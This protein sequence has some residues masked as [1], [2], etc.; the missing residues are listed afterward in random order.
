VALVPD[1]DEA[2][3]VL[4]RQP[5]VSGE[6][7]LRRQGRHHEL[8]VDGT[9]LMDTR[10]GRSE[11]LLARCA[12]DAAA[13]PRRVLVGGLGLG[14][15]LA[16]VLADPRVERVTVA[17]LEPVLVGWHR[18]FLRGLTGAA[19]V[20]PRTTVHVGDVVRLIASALPASWDAVCLDVDNGP[21]WLAR[22]QN[23]RLYGPAGVR[24]LA[25]TLDPGGALAVW[26]ANPAPDLQAR[27]REVF[28]DV[29]V[30]LPESRTS[31]PD[32]VVVAGTPDPAAASNRA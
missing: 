24:D 6:L 31:R 30:L 26:S 3:V 23:A 32:W 10:D 9:F 20:D 18:R 12:L 16:E 22:P 1:P 17:E 29:R 4:D 7:V 5:G 19:L 27:L 13:R 15:T 28:A 11:R 2:P 8:V 21:D 14:F 25:R